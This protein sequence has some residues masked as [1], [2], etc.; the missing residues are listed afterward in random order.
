MASVNLLTPLD[1]PLDNRR[2]IDDLK[3]SLISTE[4]YSELMIVIAYAK[5]G[6]IER[7]QNELKKWSSAGNTISAYIGIDQ[8]ITS[9]EALLLANELFDITYIVNHKSVTFHPKIYVF[10]GAKNGQ[11][12]LGSNNLTS[13]GLETNFEAAA[14]IDYDLTTEEDARLFREY[15]DALSDLSS[16][17]YGI[18]TQL[19]AELINTLA[20]NDLIAIETRTPGSKSSSGY[21][22]V[23]ADLKLT[24]FGLKTP[25]Q[26]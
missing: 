15:W 18:S 20:D 12:V 5:S 13:G 11:V 8:K 21:Y 10:K 2:L 19:T 26:I 25:I 9:K 6:V 23:N 24:H 7:L 1:Q 22:H 16:S 4:I 17:D 14:I 3:K